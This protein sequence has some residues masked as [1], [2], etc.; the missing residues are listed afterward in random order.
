MRY[1]V[2]K[3]FTWTVV[4]LTALLGTA[5]VSFILGG[6]GMYTILQDDFVN[7]HVDKTKTDS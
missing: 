4:I 3:T 6:L 7:K 5:V 2:Y 1:F